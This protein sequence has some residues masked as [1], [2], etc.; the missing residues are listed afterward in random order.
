MAQNSLYPAFT[1]IMYGAAGSPHT[2]VLPMIPDGVP[3][4]G[5]DPMVTTRTTSVLWSTYVTTFLNLLK[6][7]YNAATDFSVAEF[8]IME[9][10][11][12]NP[13]F[14]YGSNPA[15]SG[16]NAGANTS[17]SQTVVTFRTYA[18]GIFKLYLME[19][20]ATVNQ[21]VTAPFPA[22]ATKNLSDHIVGTQCAIVGRDGGFALAPL[23]SI[24]KTNDALRKKLLLNT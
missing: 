3:S 21:V 6:V 9:D 2:M 24:G 12:A 18:G 22:G 19:A 13:Q 10:P 14:C 7:F 23:R 15:I 8:Y 5:L 17:M 20:V 11:E 16:T 4:I 1:K